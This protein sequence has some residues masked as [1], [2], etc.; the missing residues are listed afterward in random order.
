MGKNHQTSYGVLGN[1]GNFS[2]IFLGHLD[3]AVVTVVGSPTLLQAVVP[4][5]NI[6]DLG[7]TDTFDLLSSGGG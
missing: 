1:H 3:I 7:R 4:A 2:V 6:V 5:L